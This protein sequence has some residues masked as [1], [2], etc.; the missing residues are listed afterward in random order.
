MRIT[1]GLFSRMVLQR[2][3]PN[4]CRA[5]FAGT[6]QSSGAV[7]AR[8]RAKGKTLA[9]WS[10]KR[11]GRAKRG[12][13]AGQIKALNVGGPYDIDLRIVSNGNV[14]ECLSISNVLVGDVWVLGGQS[15]M[16]G[17]GWLKDKLRP[18]P[19]V[20][21]FHMTDEWDVAIDPLHTLWCAVDPVHGG[22]PNSPRVQPH[23]WTGVGPGVAFAQDLYKRTG[24]P[25]GLLACAHGGTSMQQWDPAL[26]GQGGRS[27]YGAMCRRVRKN[28]GSVAG[29]FWYQGC[30]DASPEAAPCYTQRMK[31][32]VQAMRRDFKAPRLPVVAVQI[33]RVTRRGA[34]GEWWDSIREQQ[35]RLPTQIR[36]LAVVPAIDLP[37]DDGIHISGTGQHVLGRRAAEAMQALREGRKAGLP[38]IDVAEI[39]VKANP[40]SKMADVIVRFRN[41]AGSLA[42]PGLPAGFFLD[43]VTTMNSHYRVDLAGDKAVI[44]T[45]STVE[46]IDGGLYYGNGFDPYCNITDKAGR[47]VP[48]FGPLPMQPTR[49][50]AITPFI[51]RVAVSKVLP[52]R[53]VKKTPLPRERET[54]DPPVRRRLLRPAPRARTR[55]PGPRLL[56]LRLP[57]RR[58]DETQPAAGLRRARQGVAGPQDALLRSQGYQPRQA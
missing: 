43:T 45:Q 27:L 50:R 51:N 1:E 44:H 30:S 54:P 22:N 55:R 11:V 13:L 37:L 33:S 29:V 23:R 38:P 16:E 36:D 42:A 32:L 52:A 25:Q 4:Q 3:K 9:G 41:V 15:N 2:T 47:A 39:T 46:M 6:C 28:G 56:C 17:I 14:H 49:P 40:I 20:R 8:I 35:R 53:D 34:G 57:L 24:V 7:E 5:S 12:R 10:W 48:A 18:M 58:P 19:M 31:K 26:K 21:A